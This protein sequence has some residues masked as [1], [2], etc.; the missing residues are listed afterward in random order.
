MSNK[1][2]KN[3]EVEVIKLVEGSNDVKVIKKSTVSIHFT[4]HLM[5]ALGDEKKEPVTSSRKGVCE[6]TGIP[7]RFT[8]G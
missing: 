2:H 5:D 1:R 3:F 8:I 6:G 4:G 7:Y